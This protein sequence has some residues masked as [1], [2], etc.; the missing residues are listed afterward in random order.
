MVHVGTLRLA[1]DAE[2]K[3]D[4][5]EFITRDHDEYVSRSLVV[6][7]AKPNHQWVKEWYKVNSQDS[8]TSPEMSK[9]GKARAMKSPPTAPPDLDIPH[10]AVKHGVG[11]TERQ[12]QF[13]EVIP[14]PTQNGWMTTNAGAGRLSRSW[15]Q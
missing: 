12:F 4:L 3:L 1:F 6:D 7:G 14:A 2:Q 11:I 15:A 8:K 9:K 10:S 5:F 13:L